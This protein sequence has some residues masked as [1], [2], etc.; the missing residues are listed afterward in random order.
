MHIRAEQRP[1]GARFSFVRQSHTAGVDDLVLSNLQLELDVRMTTH[2]R[3]LWHFCERI[4]EAILRTQR[5]DG[6]LVTARRPVTEVSFSDAIDLGDEC[7]V[8]PGEPHSLGF[9]QLARCPSIDVGRDAIETIGDAE[10]MSNLSI[11]VTADES[12]VVEF[13]QKLDGLARERSPG[14]VA[15]HKDDIDALS[16]DVT[17]NG[18]ER[19]TVPV[20]VVDCGDPHRSTVA[21]VAFCGIGTH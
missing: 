10:T 1:I 13:V 9:R 5:S 21:C 8:E 14:D 2:D 7:G 18:F 11:G 19:R 17:Q 15:S 12:R 20:D 4:V 3:A 16:L 6:L